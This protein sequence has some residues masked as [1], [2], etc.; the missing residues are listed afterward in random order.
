MLIR[1][2]RVVQVLPDLL[3]SF[4]ADV[5]GFCCMTCSLA[6]RMF[7]VALCN[8]ADHYIFARWFLSF[9]FLFSSPNLSGRR[10]DVYYTSTHGVALMR[11]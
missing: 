5:I 3:H 7:M 6:C 8:R 11:I 4:L 2:E 10:M 9:F 1:S